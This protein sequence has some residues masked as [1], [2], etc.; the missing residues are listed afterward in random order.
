MDETYSISQLAKEFDI[1]TRS[2]RHYEDI[3]LVSPSRKGKTR[4]YDRKDKIR[5]KLTL[6]GKR[7]GFPLAEIKELLDM[8]DTSNLNKNRQLLATIA[9]IEQKNSELE[10]QLLDIREIQDEL[11]LAEVRC[12]TAIEKNSRNNR[13]KKL[14]SEK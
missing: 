5:L 9:K 6:R 12:R 2:I 4:I 14:S 8:Y 13:R 11:D 1:T 3:G 7:L 10:Q